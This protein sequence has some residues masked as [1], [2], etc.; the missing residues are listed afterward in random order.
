VRVAVIGTGLAGLTATALLSKA[1]HAVTALEQHE[2]IGGV[3]ATLERGGY[4]WDWGQML[5]PDFGPGEPA[6]Q[7][8]DELGASD[9]VRAVH[10]YRENYFPDFR[11]QRP[12]ECLGVYWRKDY[13]KELFPEDAAGL[14]RYYK[15]Y[16]RIHDISSL[17]GKKGLGAKLR[18]WGKLLAIARKKAW[19]A[20]QLMDSCFSRKELQAVFTA[21]LA[22]YVA[23]PKA[24]PGLLIPMINA[25]GQYDE[26]LPLQYGRHERRQSWT[27]IVG[28]MG[29]IVNALAGAARACGADIRTVE[30]VTRVRVEAGRVA[31]VISSSGAEYDADV[32]V[33]SGGARE[34]FEDLVGPEH[35]PADFLQAYVAPLFTT[36]S[37]FMVH[38][39]VDY[40]PS[41][42]QNGAALCYY[43]LTYDIDESVRRC[44]DGVYHEGDDGFLVYIPSVHSPEMAPRGR[45]AVTVYTIAP[46]HPTNGTWEQNK[47][48]WAEKLLDLAEC[49]VPGLREHEQV[50]VVLTPEDFRQRT[51]LEHH[52]FGGCVPHVKIPPPPHET[53]VPGLWLVGA[54]SEVYG[55]VAGAM[56]GTRRVVDRILGATDEVQ[57]GGA[58]RS[59]QTP[60]T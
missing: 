57:P 47:D 30:T 29:A 52:A 50:R 59:V 14:D 28:G 7:I 18:L 32:V 55:G 22:D 42:H 53:P 44:Q 17:A 2:Q 11:I 40:D 26:R 16:D 27:Y 41:V 15:I 5:V 45:H 6:R 51:H 33:A 46:N 35:L 39:G 58:R 12:R 48:K 36:E 20:Q 56:T 43:Y 38:L 9:E 8:L 4:R 21:I 10:G 31:G 1:G 25:E 13:F 60:G 49:F 23:S 54:Q 37:V 34:L 24:F 3:T 19:S